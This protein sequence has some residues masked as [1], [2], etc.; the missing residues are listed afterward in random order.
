[1]GLRDA[2]SITATTLFVRYHLVRALSSRQVCCDSSAQAC[3]HNGATPHTGSLLNQPS[4]EGDDAVNRSAAEEASSPAEQQ[5]R[6]HIAPV[7]ARDGD[8]TASHDSS[9]PH[10]VA[11]AADDLRPPQPS[12]RLPASAPP[13]SLRAALVPLYQLLLGLL[14]LGRHWL[15]YILVRA[16][17][18]TAVAL[19]ALHLLLNKVVLPLVNGSVLPGALQQAQAATLRQVGAAE[20]GPCKQ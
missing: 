16:G 4:D 18:G 3:V 5:S 9:R 6:Q 13:F 15:Q 17:V 14:R 2:P 19:L 11:S 8:P 10:D 12:S 20:H 1:M 7:A